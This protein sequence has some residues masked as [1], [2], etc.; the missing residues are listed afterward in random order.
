MKTLQQFITESMTSTYRLDNPDDVQQILSWLEK[1]GSEHETV[2]DVDNKTI[3]A[4]GITLVEDHGESVIWDYR[5]F[6]KDPIHIVPSKDWTIK[7]NDLHIQ[8]KFVS[9][10]VNLDLSPKFKKIYFSNWTVAND[11][12]ALSGA[13]TKELILQ[14]GGVGIDH[15]IKADYMCISYNS[16][17]Y[18]GKAPF[19]PTSKFSCPFVAI[20]EV[21]YASAKYIQT[22]KK[23]ELT[24]DNMPDQCRYDLRTLLQNN[25]NLTLIA[26]IQLRSPYSQ[27]TLVDDN[28]Q[29]TPL[30][31][32]N[33]V[34]AFKT[35][36]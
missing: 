35:C 1:G 33:V 2:I 31:T 14:D 27:V 11:I 8:C 25:P 32:D 15:V 22:K 36:K 34:K 24:L 7:T 5:G 13:S 16:A 3:S 4:K 10:N 6:Y 19:D 29:C 28:I 9:N 21:K 18:T 26:N 23:D 30:G 17:S 12:K 20:Q